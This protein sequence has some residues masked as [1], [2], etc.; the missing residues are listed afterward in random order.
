M[1][2]WR[3]PRR[4]GSCPETRKFIAWLAS[5]ATETSS[6]ARSMWSPW[7]VWSRFASAARTPIAAY[8]PVMM[9]TMGTPTFCG[10]YARKCTREQF[11]S[12]RY[13]VVG[14]EKLRDPLRQEFRETFG[15]ELL[16]GYGCTE[17]SPVVAI[18]TQ[19]RTIELDR[20]QYYASRF[21]TGGNQNDVIMLHYDA[22]TRVL[23][24][25]DY[26]EPENIERGDEILVD[27]ELVANRWVAEDIV[28]TVASA[29]EHRIVRVPSLDI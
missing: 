19:N 15:K 5:I 9:S 7:P 21:S 6:M 10:A 1:F 11:A 8:M 12:L 25:G 29:E 23:Y 4:T 14:A 27:A 3:L 24:E 22:R 2:G 16:E 17:L 20:D 18:N 28:E 26:Y 13:V